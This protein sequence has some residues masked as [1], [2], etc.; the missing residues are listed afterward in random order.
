MTHE[1]L[2]LM[3]PKRVRIAPDPRADI[4]GT[5]AVRV[6]GGGLR[7]STLEVPGQDGVVSTKLGY[8]PAEVQVE[9]RVVDPGQLSAL[10]AFADAYRNRRGAERHEPVQ[11]VHPA[12][13]RWGIREAYLTDIEEEPWS[14]REGYRLRLTFREWWPESRTKAVR[15]QEGGSGD[16]GTLGQGMS[17]LEAERPSAKPP[18]PRR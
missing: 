10:R 3:G 6:R 16:G 11:I 15:K 12:T 1:E 2:V 17:P 8:A 4:V 7:E 5:V 9:V 14:P 18:G 13:H